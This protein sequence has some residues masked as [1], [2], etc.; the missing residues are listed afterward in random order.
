M[1]ES[2]TIMTGAI[3]QQV[4]IGTYKAPSQNRKDPEGRYR[5]ERWLATIKKIVSAMGA[6]LHLTPTRPTRRVPP[7]SNC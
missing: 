1:F 4:T 5:A 3:I 2:P 6:G 7:A